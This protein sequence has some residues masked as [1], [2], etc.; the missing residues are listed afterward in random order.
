L[1]RRFEVPPVIGARLVMGISA[2]GLLISAELI[3]GLTLF[4]RTLAD[5]LA[6]WRS[7]AG[8]LGFTAQ[9]IFAAMP[10]IALTRRQIR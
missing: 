10:L 2:F 5:Q 4:N 6:A 3:L 9:I 7:P 1:I 8:A